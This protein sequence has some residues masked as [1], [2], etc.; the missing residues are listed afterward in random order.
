MYLSPIIILSLNRQVIS[1]LEPKFFEFDDD[2][3]KMN[4]EQFVLFLQ[5]K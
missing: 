3:Y 2:A 5:N 4:K 1:T